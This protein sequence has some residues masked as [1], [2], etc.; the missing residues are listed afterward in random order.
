VSFSALDGPSEI[1]SVDTTGTNIQASYDLATNTLSLQ[2]L[3]SL[4][5]YEMVLETLVYE[6]Q[7]SNNPL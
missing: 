6:N 2:G 5:N 7:N 1:L 3:D 4:Q